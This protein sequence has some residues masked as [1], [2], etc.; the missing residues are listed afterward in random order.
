VDIFISYRRQDTAGY[1]LGLRREL[2]RALPDAKVFLDV[3]S[4]DAGM[5]WRQVICERVAQC[6]LML[7]IIGD[8][9]L[10]TRADEKKIDRKDDPVRFEL[11]AAFSRPGMQLIPIL[12]EDTPMPPVRELPESVRAMCDFSAHAIHD[13]TYDQDVN[14][15]LE[16]LTRLSTQNEQAQAPPQPPR[17]ATKAPPPPTGP[18]PPPVAET[19]L[20]SK[21]TERYVY[22]IVPGMGRDQL[23]ALIAELV[24]RGWDA[25]EIYEYGLSCSSLQPSKGFPA[26]I[27]LSWLAANVP[28]LS[29]N[30]VDK[31]IREL[32]KR[33]W[34]PEDVR[35]HVLGNRQAALA[36]PLPARIQESW[37][38]RYAP[39][40]TADEQDALAEALIN[41]RW[42]V[43]EIRAY[44]P[45]ARI[46]DM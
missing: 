14:A 38:G 45:Y 28:L 33:N 7:V 25:E 2:A 31:L 18:E 37:V 23:L 40:M 27:T 9:W 44:M 20:P 43:A 1:A 19:T 35:S 30:R 36:P 3:E 46:P 29:P 16:L 10:V 6:D 17:G 15:L 42:T 11:E 4:L 34:S 21:I 13:R 41:K 32:L 39:L 8:E 26:R 12:V 5:R 24:R 22:E